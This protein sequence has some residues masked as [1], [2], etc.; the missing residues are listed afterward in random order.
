MQVR[1]R[2]AEAGRRPVGAE[3]RE[4]PV[5]TAAGG[6]RGSEIRHRDLEH[7]AGVIGERRN[8]TEV[9]PN[10]TADAGCLEEGTEGVERVERAQRRRRC[11]GARIGQVRR[12][13]AEA[14]L[15]RRDPVRAQSGGPRRADR[16]DKVAGVGGGAGGLAGL[17]RQLGDEPIH[18]ADMADVD[19]GGEESAAS[20][21]VREERD[22][23]GIGAQR[24]IPDEL[25]AGLVVLTLGSAHR[26]LFAEDRRE[27]R[28]PQRCVRVMSGRKA[29]SRP[30]R[31]RNRSIRRSSTVTAPSASST[32]GGSSGT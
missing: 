32:A 2:D 29:R 6:D 31:S 27:V 13:I 30:S 15:E 21:R 23:L 14:P 3:A 10:G 24:R 18:E 19:V 7:D 16:A 11:A 17:G 5:V 9:E 8:E 28:E 4:E 22:D 25:D 20:E 26:R 12:A 1:D